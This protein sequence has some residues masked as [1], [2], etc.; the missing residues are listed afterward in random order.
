VFVTVPLREH[1][2][3]QPQICSYQVTLYLRQ[4]QTQ[5]LRW[6][7]DAQRLAQAFAKHCFR[8]VLAVNEF[9]TLSFDSTV[10]AFRV[11]AAHTLDAAARE[12]TL[13]EE[14]LK[15]MATEDTDL[16]ARRCL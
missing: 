8:S 12:V 10:L 15:L 16:D 13:I 5:Q 2:A 11:T 6:Q 1:Q 9:V 14:S 3:T 4:A 7:V